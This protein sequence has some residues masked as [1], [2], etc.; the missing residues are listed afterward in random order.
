MNEELT[1]ARAKRSLEVAE[2]AREL[3]MDCRDHGYVDRLQAERDCYREAL[4]FYAKGYTRGSE[5]HTDDCDTKAG[6]YKHGK[7]ARAALS[8]NEAS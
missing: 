5:Q 2:E 3:G 7:R 8:R 6:G 4:E 1:L